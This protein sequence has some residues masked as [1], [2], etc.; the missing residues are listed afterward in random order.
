LGSYSSK[1][2]VE[3]EVGGFPVPGDWPNKGPFETIANLFRRKRVADRPDE[4]PSAD[5]GE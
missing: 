5:E 4:E 1:R 3:G 2:V